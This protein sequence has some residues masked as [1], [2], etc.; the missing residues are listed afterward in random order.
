MISAPSEMRC[1]SMPSKYMTRNVSASTSG[2]HS[3]TTRPVRRPSE[4]KL[5]SSTMTTASSRLFLNSCTDS[6]TTRGWSETAW[7]CTP[8][9]R[10]AWMRATVAVSCSPRRITSPPLRMLTASPTASSPLKRIFDVAGSTTPRSTWA[11]SPSRNMRS[12]ARMPM[13]RML[14]TES[15]SPLTV[16]RTGFGG[17]LHRAGRVHG[18]GRGQGR[19]DQRRVDAERR[20]LGVGRLDIDLRVLHAHQ[21]DLVDVGD[22]QEFI[23]RG[24]GEVA[25]LGRAEAVAG[26]RI[27]AAEGVAELVV[28][29]R[30]AHAL[31]QRVLDVAELLAHLVPHLRHRGRRRVLAQV[32]LDLR[33]A[34]LG[35]AAGVVDLGH[36]LQLLLQLVGHLLGHLLRR[37]A[38]PVR[39]HDHGLDGEL[40]VFLLAELSVGEHPRDAEQQQQEDD[41]LRVLQRP[42]GEVDVAH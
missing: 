13:L 18:V 21:L 35:V 1:S 37:A 3:A 34:R 28:E 33:D 5:T 30:T 26:D 24:V 39:L 19:G 4:K 2:M 36:F 10:F 11:M 41:H 40:G 16:R 42:L 7:I 31:R 14:S 17:G 25:Q 9:G 6:S 8:I 38:G 12:P 27:Q 15:N 32:D 29:V 20:Q 23:A 22:A